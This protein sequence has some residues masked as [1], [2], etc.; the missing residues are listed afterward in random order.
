MISP[1]LYQTEIASSVLNILLSEKINE[2]LPTFSHGDVHDICK[3]AWNIARTMN[4]YRE[5]NLKDF[6]PDSYECE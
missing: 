4:H 2:K 1:F 6:Y 3:A 5:E